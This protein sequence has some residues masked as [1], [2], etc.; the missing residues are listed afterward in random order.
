MAMMDRLVV[1][2]RHGQAWFFSACALDALLQ[3]ADKWDDSSA[4]LLQAY[5]EGIVRVLVRKE[6]SEQEKAT[7]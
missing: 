3:A 4:E 1:Y 6:T 2:P 5:K 7:V